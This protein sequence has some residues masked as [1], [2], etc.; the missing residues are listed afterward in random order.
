M[1][2]FGQVEPTS[3]LSMERRA[4]VLGSG[5]NAAYAWE[6]SLLAGMAEAGVDLCGVDLFIGTSAGARVAVELANGVSLSDLLETQL[7]PKP[8]TESTPRIDLQQWRE[9]VVSAR[10][11]I[12][13][14]REILRRMGRLALSTAP[15][16]QAARR[17]SLAALLSSNTWPSRKLRLVAVEA[18][19]GVRTA[20]D[21]TSGIELLD[22][23]LASSAVA[24]IYAPVPFRGRHYFDGG[25]Y[26]TENADLAVGCERVLILALRAGR[27]PLGVVSLREQMEILRRGGAAVRV[28]HPDE[29]AEA[30]VSAV[31]GNVLDP[32]VAAPAAR[33]GRAQG[34]R[35]IEERGMQVWP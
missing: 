14:Q 13:D 10:E 24:G 3:D 21:A 25:F 19:T 6:V 2:P 23:V 31:N 7:A 28:I 9:A 8:Q 20:F 30:A 11:G 34:R 16:P 17:E 33:A 12:A 29:S 5:G 26:S 22:A 15:Q 18:E 4:L 32:S 1:V 27:S 35:L